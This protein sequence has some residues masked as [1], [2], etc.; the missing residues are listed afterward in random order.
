MDILVGIGE[1]PICCL[2]FFFFSPSVA[3]KLDFWL[4]LTLKKKN[5][6][7]SHVKVFQLTRFSKFGHVVDNVGE[8]RKW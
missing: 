1:F 5:K 4:T 8:G 3:I 2:F 6:H 7:H